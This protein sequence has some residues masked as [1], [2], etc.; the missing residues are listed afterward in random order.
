MP[1]AVILPYGLHEH[2]TKDAQQQE[3]EFSSYVRDVAGSQSPADQL[4]KLADLRD[5]GVITA[6][7]SDREKAKILT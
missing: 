7:E 1:A 5:R 2:A 3:R 4:S 6:E